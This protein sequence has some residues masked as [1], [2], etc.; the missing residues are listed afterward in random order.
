MV[1]RGIGKLACPNRLGQEPGA[2]F[3]FID[4]IFNQAGRRHIVVLVADGVHAAKRSSELL[5]VGRQFSQHVV[6]RDEFLVVV[7]QSLVAC[8]ISDRI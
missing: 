3:C 4:P 7:L 1:S 2:A 5:I 6:G 8:D